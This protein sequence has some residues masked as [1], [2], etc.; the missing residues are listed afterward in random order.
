MCRLIQHLDGHRKVVVPKP[1]VEGLQSFV[2]PD[3]WWQQEK[4][5]TWIMGILLQVF[6]EADASDSGGC[7]ACDELG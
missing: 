5:M 7:C 2:L 4:G 3:Q 6:L 1:G